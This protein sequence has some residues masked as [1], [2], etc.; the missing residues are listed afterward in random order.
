MFILIHSKITFF[1]Y[2]GP[3]PDHLTWPDRGWNVP[4]IFLYIGTINMFNESGTEMYN[5]ILIE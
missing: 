3:E 5:I 1:S 4:L 2:Y